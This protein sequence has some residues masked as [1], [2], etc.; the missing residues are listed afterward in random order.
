MLVD[1][2]EKTDQI[3][4]TLLFVIADHGEAFYQHAKNYI[5]ALFLYEENVAI[6]F[7]IYNK[8]IFKETVRY[9]GFTRHVDVLPT[10]KDILGLKPAKTEEGISMFASRRE[11]LVLL[12][13]NWKDDF[14]GVRDGDWKY[15]YRVWDGFEELYNIK[16]DPDEKK[17]IAAERQDI[18]SMYKKYL[19]NARRY[20]IQYYKKV[21]PGYRPSLK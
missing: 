1:E 13:T 19:L 11:Q 16:N 10:V 4:N 15:I 3:D 7:M 14:L 20:K 18:S 5:H 6:P 21:I 9:K 8:K 17:N 12:H 2:L